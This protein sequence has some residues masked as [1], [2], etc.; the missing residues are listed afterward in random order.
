MDNTFYLEDWRVEPNLLRISRAGRSKQVEP[1]L[2]SLLLYLAESPGQVIPKAELRAAV[3][4]EII[5]T[6]NVLTKAI[7]SLRRLLEDNSTNPRYIETISKKGYRLI[8]GVKPF[9]QPKRYTQKSSSWNR[10]GF[11]LG[12]ILVLVLGVSLLSTDFNSSAPLVYHPRP[13]ANAS[14]TEYWPAISPDGKFVAY[15]WQGIEQNNWD[16]YVKQIGSTTAKRFT[17][18]PATE[19]RAKWSP[20]GSHLYYLRYDKGGAI[21]FKRPLLEGEEVQ[22]LKA[23][24]YSSGD[25]N[26]SPDER[27]ISFNN[28]EK[29][30]HPARIQLI[31]IETGESKWLTQPDSSFKGDIHPTFSRDGSQ[32]AFIR[33]KNATSMQLWQLSTKD[34]KLEQLTHEHQSING[35]SWS[36]DNRQLFY[37]GDLTGLYKIWQVNLNNGK[38]QLLPIGDFQ[39]VMPRVAD[40]GSMIY[41]KM[42]DDVNIWTYDLETGQA[43]SWRRQEGL[44]LNPNISP[45]GKQVSFTARVGDKFQIWMANLDGSASRPITDYSGD[46]LDGVRWTEDGTQLLFHGYREGKVNVFKVNSQGGPIQ[47]VGNATE[48]RVLPFQAQDGKL[49]YSRKKAH[50]WEIWKMA[51]DGTQ[52][53]RVLSDNAYAPQISPDQSTLFYCKKDKTGLWAF[54]LYKEREQLI[55]A[56]FHPMYSGAFC[57]AT[58]GLYYWNATQKQIAYFDFKRQKSKLLFRPSGRIPRL[59]ITLHYSPQQDL[60]IFTQVDHRDADIMMVEESNAM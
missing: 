22:V 18:N 39:M 47:R 9:E 55:L 30:G 51:L 36:A 38:S 21:I 56:D 40:D 24:R 59:G 17:R 23:P 37:S 6:D 43:K 46:Y 4:G 11:S 28:R 35:F 54:N 44:E 8:A 33:E 16:I 3:W 29:P 58:E 31:A 42:K 10:V 19:L 25:F 7:S 53:E 57:P 48:D 5:V 26:I 12:T 60:L 15:G 20:D 14:T 34:G 49:Y 32:L 52:A 45:D 1:L 41:A 50:Q 27:W 13:L 2:M